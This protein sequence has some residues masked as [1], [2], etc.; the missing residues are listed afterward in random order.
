[1]KKLTDKKTLYLNRAQN[2]IFQIGAKNLTVIGSRRVG[3]SEG[4]IMPVLLRNVQAMPKSN[5]AIVGTSYKQILTRTLPATLHALSRLNYQEGVHFFVG[6]RAPKKANFQEPYIMPR[7]WDYIIHWYNGSINTLISQDVPFSSN[8]LTTDYDIIDEAKTINYEKLVNETFPAN[9]GLYHFKE[10]PWH[11]GITIVT[12][13]PTNKAGEWIF[14]KSQELDKELLSVIETIIF[15]IWKLKQ[16]PNSNLPHIQNQINNLNKELNFYRSKLSLFMVLNILDNLEVVGVQYVDDMFRNLPPHVFLSA[17]LSLK[18]KNVDGLFYAAIDKNKHYY[19]AV[20]NSFLNNFRRKDG[21]IDVKKACSHKYNCLQDTDIDKNKPLYIAF[22]TNININWIVIGQP[23]YLNNKLKILNS[24][25]VKT[26]MML[27]ELIQKFCNY[28]SSL[29]NKHV[30]F[31]YDQ[32]FLQGRSGTSSESFSETIIRVLTANNYYVTDV[33]IG[34]A[35]RH[36][37]KHKSIDMA[38]KG[39]K[40]LMPVFNEI[41]N[42]ALISALEKAGTKLTAL[43]WGKDK[44][45]EKLPDTE[46]NPT[47]HRT[48]GTDAFDTL[49]IGCNNFPQYISEESIILSTKFY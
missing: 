9:S 21:S 25:F 20:N 37:I 49:F 26:P 47:E 34:Q 14:K 31:Y 38:L 33:Y 24:I 7:S 22:D 3:K 40:G 23:D 35:E 41:N 17:I 30:V 4:I 27:P 11:T 45:E 19:T 12:D 46:E 6:R 39:Q 42:E 8:S 15:E 43:G 2:Y 16:K 18:V 44:S 28:Y 13:M 1:M 5:G 32:T 36:A 48:D 10:S 29:P